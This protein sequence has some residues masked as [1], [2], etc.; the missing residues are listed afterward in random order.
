MITFRGIK[1]EPVAFLGFLS[2]KLCHTIEATQYKTK[3]TC[4]TL[5]GETKGAQAD[6]AC[7]RNVGAQAR[8]NDGKGVQAWINY[9]Y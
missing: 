3:K 4:K 6:K 5:I 9:Y 7:V 8:T 1:P 2:L